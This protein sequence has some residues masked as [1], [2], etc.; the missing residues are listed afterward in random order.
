MFRDEEVE[1]ALEVVDGAFTTP[2]Y[3]LLGVFSDSDELIGYA[4][5]GPT[6]DTDGTFDLYWI[7]VDRAAQGSGA[8]SF[9]LGAVEQQIENVGARL[10]V[11][12]TSS[13]SDYAATRGFYERRGFVEAARVGAFYA[14]GDDRVI[15]TKRF[16]SRPNAGR[17]VE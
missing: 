17:G 3:A 14:P 7:A 11:L 6:P 16:T 2:D 4:A 5:Y 9:L 10:L 8:G 15:F 1:V 12:E 13:R